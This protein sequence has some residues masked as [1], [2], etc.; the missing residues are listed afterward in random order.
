MALGIFMFSP[1]LY[2][3]CK[4]AAAGRHEML[5]PILGTHSRDVAMRIVYPL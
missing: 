2:Y 5:G 3:L 4:W 1:P